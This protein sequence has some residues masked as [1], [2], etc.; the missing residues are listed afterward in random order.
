AHT[1]APTAPHTPGAENEWAGALALLANEGTLERAEL[2]DRCLA[3]L[4]RGDRP[5]NLRGF[6]LLTERLAPDND[7]V[8]SRLAT[9]VA[10]AARGAGPCARLAQNALRELDDAGRLGSVTLAELSKAVLARPE[11][12]LVAAQL[13]W[14][15]TAVRR[16][17]SRAPELLNATS[18][19]FAHPAVT[20]QE[21]ALRVVIR[22]LRH[23]DTTQTAALQD[24]ARQL[25]A[26]LR[27]EA[28]RVLGGNATT[29]AASQTPPALLP[30]Y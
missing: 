3:K 14:V 22:H 1:P 23:L 13:S 5:A 15:D 6:G 19:A 27:D 12:S 10:L 21:R 7:E 11:R 9:Y 30:P 4:L 24:A 25:D 18:A 8:A 2:L 26:V 17:S 28:T 29:A 20:V 16:D